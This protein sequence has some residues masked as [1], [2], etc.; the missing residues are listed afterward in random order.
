M[1]LSLNDEARS[2]SFNDEDVSVIH[3]DGTVEKRHLEDAI[4]QGSL[5]D[6]GVAQT[7][8]EATS[9][10]TASANRKKRRQS[11]ASKKF[12]ALARFS[13]KSNS[14]NNLGLSAYKPRL[15]FYE[16][17]LSEDC[18]SQEVRFYGP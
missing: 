11:A 16:S 17:G 10:A 18:V 9:A 15:L 2:L 1:S 8:E 3:E 12:G 5:S 13:K 14:L 6:G 7:T 4:E